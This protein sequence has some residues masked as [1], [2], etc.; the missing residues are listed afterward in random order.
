[1][2]VDDMEIGEKE[3]KTRKICGILKCILVNQGKTVSREVLSTT[4]WL[5]SD[6]KAAY[7]S[8]RIA[9]FELKK[10]LARY[11]MAFESEDAIIAEGKN[12]FYLCSRNTVKTDAD[13]FSELYRKYRSENLSP[14]EVQ[15]LLPQMTELYEGDFLE[16]DPYDEW[17]AL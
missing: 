2:A 3:W 8:L 9:L 11:G 16:E 1:M 6:S 7:T 15:D 10:L 17:V 4:F 14:E 12:G 5:E 13:R